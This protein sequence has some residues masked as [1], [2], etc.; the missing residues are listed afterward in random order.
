MLQAITSWGLLVAIALCFVS[1][2]AQVSTA[3]LYGTVTDPMKDNVA[4]AKLTVRSL[5]TG[6]VRSL[7]TDDEGRFSSEPRA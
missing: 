3:T 6:A 4:H 2:S 1:A 7:V 5:A